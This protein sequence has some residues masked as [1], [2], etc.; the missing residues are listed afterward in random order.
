MNNLFITHTPYHVILAAGLASTEYLD[1]INDL[2]IF[3]DFPISK[4]DVLSIRNIFRNI[5]FVDGEY[6]KTKIQRLTQVSNILNKV[7]K[8]LPLQT[9]NRVFIHNDYK[10]EV[11]QIV[12]VLER[13]TIVEIIYIEDGSAAYSDVICKGRVSG[14]I[15]NI[16]NILMINKRYETI[17]VI[18]TYSR[19]ERIKVLWPKLV[20]DELC[21]KHI[22]EINVESLEMGIKAVYNTFQYPEDFKSGVLILLEHSASWIV[23]NDEYINAINK[24]LMICKSMGLKVYIK[25]HPRESIYYLNDISRHEAIVIDQDIPAEALFIRIQNENIKIIS[26]V[27]TTLFTAAKLIESNRIISL[28]KLSAANNSWIINC[29]SKMGIQSPQNMD[30]LWNSLIDIHI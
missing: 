11:Q 4:I 26:F 27:S 16:I 3:E 28:A 22:E 9:Y 25:Y 30:E 18:G 2:V 13:F 5:L 14:L 1:D 19:V 7:K 12:E 8:N 29:F 17:K 20:R 21:N 10:L 24:V 15:K 23:Q 6:K